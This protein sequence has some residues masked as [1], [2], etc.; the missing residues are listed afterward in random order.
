MITIL[1][2]NVKGGCGKTTVAT[3]LA[4]AY[5]V[6]G[7][8]T[9][10]ADVDRQRSSWGWIERRPDSAAKV[11]GADW[12]KE[13]GK[14]PK[15]LARLVIDFP[16]AGQQAMLNAASPVSA[17]RTRV[18]SIVARNFDRDK[19]VD[20]LIAFQHR[21]YGEDQAI[22]ERQNPEDLPIDLGEEVHVRADLTSVTYRRQLGALGLGRGFTA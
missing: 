7:Q 21:I 18:F 9:L 20:E 1:V 17:R 22:V 4:A 5:A 10:L 12:S 19:S 16:G 13:I 3:H 2:A 6:A 11:A 8:P 14:P 15:G